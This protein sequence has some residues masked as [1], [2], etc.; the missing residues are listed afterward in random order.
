VLFAWAAVFAIGAVGV[1][2]LWRRYLK[3][4]GE[5]SDQRRAMKQEV[6]RLRDTV[7]KGSPG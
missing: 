1:L 3:Q 7:R 5:L 2:L 4:L 6:E